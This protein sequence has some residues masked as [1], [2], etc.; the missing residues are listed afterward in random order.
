MAQ[1]IKNSDVLIAAGWQIVVAHDKRWFANPKLDNEPVFIVD[2]VDSMDTSMFLAIVTA[3]AF[4][5][6]TRWQ[7]NQTKNHIKERLYKQLDRI[8]EQL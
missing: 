4:N 6:G 2:D 1:Q 5:N 8:V 7:R 3:T